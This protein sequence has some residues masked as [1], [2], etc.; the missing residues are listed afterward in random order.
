MEILKHVEVE[1]A[2][3]L[4]LLGPGAAGGAEGERGGA[5]LGEAVDEIGAIEGD[6]EG[7]G[8]RA[9]WARVGVAPELLLPGLA[10][11]L[12]LL[13]RLEVEEAVGVEGEDGSPRAG[14]AD[15]QL[16]RIVLDD[17][18]D[19]GGQRE[20]GDAGGGGLGL[21][22]VERARLDVRE[23]HVG[24]LEAAVR[25]RVGRVVLVDLEAERV[26]GQ[27]GE[28]EQERAEAGRV[29]ERGGEGAVGGDGERGGVEGERRVERV[30]GAGARA[31][32]E[33]GLVAVAE[34]VLL[35]G[36][37]GRGGG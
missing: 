37:G 2:I 3:G 26:R 12:G 21:R 1:E 8:L 31:L 17:D 25:R 11:L 27:R 20:G 30:R 32:A 22:E 15:G 9:A 5:V 7:D 28:A 35:P 18:V 36:A 34:L 10:L 33:G 14:A 24:D 16:E 19:V 6:V 29:G 23:E 13:Q 4:G